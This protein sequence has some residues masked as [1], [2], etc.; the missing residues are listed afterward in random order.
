MQNISLYSVKKEQI[1]INR[2]NS[3][4]RIQADNKKSQIFKIRTLI[5]GSFTNSMRILYKSDKTKH[6]GISTWRPLKK[7]SVKI[8]PK[9]KA[10]IKKKQFFHI[11]NS[12]NYYEDNTTNIIVHKNNLQTWICKT[13]KKSNQQFFGM[14]KYWFNQRRNPL[15]KW[16]WDAISMFT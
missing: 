2:P 5:H 4:W 16:L 3:S 12:N 8:Q 14:K 11:N 6:T 10:M 1:K 7:I 13:L 15:D 9:K